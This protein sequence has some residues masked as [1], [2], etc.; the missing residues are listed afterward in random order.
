MPHLLRQHIEH[1]REV[2]HRPWHLSGYR[3]RK[4]WLIGW[5]AVPG[6]PLS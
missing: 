5:Q 2:L 3:V 6:A 1:G 4:S